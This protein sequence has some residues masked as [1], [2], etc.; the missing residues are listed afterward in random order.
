MYIILVYYTS[1]VNVAS[2][3]F[4]DFTQPDSKTDGLPLR[5]SESYNYLS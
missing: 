4:S 3:A 1:I 2:L 5:I